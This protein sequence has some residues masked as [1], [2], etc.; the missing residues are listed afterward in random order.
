MDAIAL[1]KQD[2]RTVED[3]F[4][5]FE[6]A[7]DRAYKTKRRLVDEIITELSIHAAVEEQVFYPATREARRETEDMVL[8]S[9][10]EHHLV[11]LALLELEQ[12]DPE[13]ERFKAK[14][15]VLIENVRHHV[16]EEEGE[17][18]PKVRKAMKPAQLEALGQQLEEAKLS[19]PTRPHPSA[20]DTPPGNVLAGS[21]SAVVD[22]GKDA[23]RGIKEEISRRT[24]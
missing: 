21:M 5:R 23:A 2:H 8:E 9:L 13:D 15:T 1:L 16:E 19:A 12:M 10:E 6:K 4:K 11:K 24:G 22:A 17:L 3:L 20:P 14:V 7:G 18:F